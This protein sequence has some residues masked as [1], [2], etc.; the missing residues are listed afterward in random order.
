M[1]GNKI[2]KYIFVIKLFEVVIEADD[3]IDYKLV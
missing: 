3:L 1:F 2:F